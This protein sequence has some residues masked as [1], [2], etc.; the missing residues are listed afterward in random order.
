MPRIETT[1]SRKLAHRR[2]RR[3]ATLALAS[4]AVLAASF[5]PADAASA[6]S[7][8]RHHPYG[9]NAKAAKAFATVPANGWTSGIS[10][11]GKTIEVF[12]HKIDV[13]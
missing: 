10:S 4:V 8:N 12:G 11:R 2:S 13:P 7:H 5:A 6:K 9:A 1:V 3:F